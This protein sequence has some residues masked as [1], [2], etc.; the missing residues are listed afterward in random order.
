MYTELGPASQ[1][2]STALIR[3][4]NCRT[5]VHNFFAS[6]SPLTVIIMAEP[7]LP[8][9]YA[10][11]SWSSLINHR[12]IVF[13]YTSVDNLNFRFKSFIFLS[14]RYLSRSIPSNF[15]CCQCSSISTLTTTW[16][17][18]FTVRM[19]TFDSRELN[20]PAFACSISKAT[21]ALSS[22]IYAGREHL[23]VIWLIDR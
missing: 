19:S 1:Y 3:P 17:T 20:N 8:V 7:C 16:S 14:P 6:V 11:L 22:Y 12:G 2:F 13:S 21:Y 5:D 10:S 23:G 15:N 18:V 4:P 9:V